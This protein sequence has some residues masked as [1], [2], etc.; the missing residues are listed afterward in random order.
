ML[1]LELVRIDHEEGQPTEGVVVAGLAAS[2]AGIGEV[3][4]ELIHTQARA[5]GE[6]VA[7]RVAGGEVFPQFVWRPVRA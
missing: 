2:E 1:R 5:M 7:Y 3:R 4:A 6:V